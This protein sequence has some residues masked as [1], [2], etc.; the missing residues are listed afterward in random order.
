MPKWHD[1]TCESLLKKIKHSGNL[2]KKYPANSY[3]R[4]YIQSETKQYRKLVKSKH[5][6]FINKENPRG[7]MN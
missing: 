3:L 4:E 7:Y 5:K 6:Q 1:E 2:L